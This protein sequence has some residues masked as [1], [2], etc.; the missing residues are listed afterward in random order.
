MEIWGFLRNHQVTCLKILGEDAKEDAKRLLRECKN[1]RV[2]VSYLN[3]LGDEAKKEARCLL[4]SG[5]EEWL[6]VTCIRVLGKEVKFETNRLIKNSNNRFVRK[7]CRELIC[8]WETSIG[9]QFPE[10]ARLKKNLAD[11]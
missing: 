6:L 10:L 3:I 2:L 11:K 5:K 7:E 8:S 4:K 9:S 1:E